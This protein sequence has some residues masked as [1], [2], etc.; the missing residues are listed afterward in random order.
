MY[1]TYVRQIMQR[2]AIL[3]CAVDF[4]QQKRA[5]HEHSVHAEPRN[6]EYCLANVRVLFRST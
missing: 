1:A 2:T 5:K 3:F 4:S 6:P